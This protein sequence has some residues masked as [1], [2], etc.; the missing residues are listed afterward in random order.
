LSTPGPGGS[1]GGFSMKR[2]EEGTA[3]ETSVI[4]L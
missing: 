2:A 4:K 3:P 1:G